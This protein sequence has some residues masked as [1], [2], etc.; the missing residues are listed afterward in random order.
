M[1]ARKVLE[2]I[3]SGSR[4]VRF[5][6]FQYLIEAYGFTL[7]R[8]RGSHHHYTH[9]DVPDRLSIQPGKD[10][11]AK[12]YQIAQFLALVDEHQL[13]LKDQP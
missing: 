13:R 4:N 7:R 1:K 10:G 12:H 8:T 9:P 5:E 11:K 3:R 2:K 6:E